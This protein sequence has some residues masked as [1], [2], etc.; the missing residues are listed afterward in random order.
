MQTVEDMPVHGGALPPA[1]V[2]GLPGD[3]ILSRKMDGGKDCLRPR[4]R[5]AAMRFAQNDARRQVE[6]A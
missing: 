3:A 4:A 5:R 2:E 1:T 6:G